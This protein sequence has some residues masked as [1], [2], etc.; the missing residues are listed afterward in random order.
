M[1]TKKR[2]QKKATAK[3]A[4]ST[5]T[6]QDDKALTAYLKEPNYTKLATKFNM[7]PM[8][9]RARVLRAAERKG[10]DLSKAVSE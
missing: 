3:K 10:V 8:G 6:R 9:F 7:S 2:N 1:A 4:D 5:R